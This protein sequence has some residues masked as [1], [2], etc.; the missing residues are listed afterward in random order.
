M[1]LLTFRIRYP[2][3]ATSSDALA[4]SGLDEAALSVDPNV[5][6]QKFD[7][8]HGAFAAHLLWTGVHGASIRLDGD[9]KPDEKSRYW[10]EFARLRREV[11][12]R[13]WVI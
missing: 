13:F 9:S 11:A 10:E 1:N 12:P 2:E 6:G 7:A 5:Y 8:A 4:Q 3:F